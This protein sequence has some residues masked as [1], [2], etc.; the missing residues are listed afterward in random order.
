MREYSNW[1]NL[2]IFILKIEILDALLHTAVNNCIA[3][4][5][6]A[7]FQVKRSLYASKI[8][9]AKE[10]DAVSTSAHSE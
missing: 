2:T 6:L 4:F 7:S 8:L 10:R 9:K 5:F 3:F 1:T